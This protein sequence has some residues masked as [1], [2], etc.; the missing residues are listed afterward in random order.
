MKSRNVNGEEEKPVLPSEREMAADRSQPGKRTVP[1]GKK[2]G[3]PLEERRVIRKEGKLSSSA[4]PKGSEEARELDWAL[5]R[6]SGRKAEDRTG[7]R[8]GD[9]ETSGEKKKPLSKSEERLKSFGRVGQWF[10][11]LCWINIPVIGFIYVIVLA[12]RKKT[13]PQ[14][15]SFAIA[16]LLYRLLV[17]CIA[18]TI[19]YVLY[20]VGL[21]FVAE[22]LR[23]AGSALG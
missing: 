6:M 13:P 22:I 15:R 4:E 8:E 14:K 18:L 7:L 5:A 1:S 3:Q 10:Q 20:K 2:E 12:L 17:L 23:Y 9:A 11:T 16:Y 19:L 21:S